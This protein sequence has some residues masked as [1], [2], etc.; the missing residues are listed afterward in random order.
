MAKI[1]VQRRAASSIIKSV[2][3]RGP[4]P[5]HARVDDGASSTGH[6]FG[7]RERFAFL[8]A[9]AVSMSWYY[10]LRRERSP[11]VAEHCCSRSP[12]RQAVVMLGLAPAVRAVLH[13]RC[14]AGRDTF[15][16]YLCLPVA[17][18]DSLAPHA[19][20]ARLQHAELAL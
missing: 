9:D 19:T 13:G 10:D 3:S 16:G 1:D 11:R 18:E 4:A 7:V 20:R 6:A 8:E 15:V 12:P 5:A 14:C 2:L 17:A